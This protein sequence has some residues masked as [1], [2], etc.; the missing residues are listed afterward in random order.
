MRKLRLLLLNACMAFAALTGCTNR[1]HANVGILYCASESNSI[2]QAKV[3]KEELKKKGYTSKFISFADSKDISPVLRGN[4]NTVDT[5]YIPTDNV[6]ASNG[7]TINAIAREFKKPVFA[8][9]EGICKDAGGVT[10]SIN[11]FTL[12]VITGK[13]AVDI[14]LG[15]RDIATMPIQY[16]ENPVKKYNKDFCEELNINV[17]ED[18]VE[19]GGDV[20]EVVDVEFQNTD[21]RQFTIGVS[22]LVPHTALDAATRGF[23]AAVK[24]GLGENN[25]TIL[26]QDAAGDAGVCTTIANT[27]VSRKVDLIMANATPAVQAA[28]NATTTIPVLGTSVTDYGTALSI[29]DFDGTVGGNVSGTSDLVAL[30]QQVEMLCDLFASYMK[31]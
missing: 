26:H 28:A 7:E 23:N 14:L 12:G 30:N 25:V 13:M 19:I 29:S 6:C 17:P 1:Q 4:V 22:Q 31:K 16:D 9:E 11:Y 8:G 10:L 18:Y 20:P 5:L 21:N 27:F 3:V 2:Y 24:A 15:N